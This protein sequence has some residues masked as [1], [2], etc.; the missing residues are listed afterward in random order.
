M[1]HEPNQT[2][3]QNRPIMNTSY[4]VNIVINIK[5]LLIPNWLTMGENNTN[6][7][8]ILICVEEIKHMSIQLYVT[9]AI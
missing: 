8:Q 7:H 4:L 1:P 3:E 9:D 6:S 2:A 5:S